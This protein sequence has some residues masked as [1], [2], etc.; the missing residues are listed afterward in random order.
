[1]KEKLMGTT[2]GNIHIYKEKP[3]IIKTLLSDEHIVLSISKDWVSILNPS[4]GSEGSD[5]TAK[6]ISKS[7]S[8]PVFAFQYH[9]DDIMSLSMYKDGKTIARHYMNCSYV[10]YTKN[11]KGFVEGIGLEAK[12]QTKLNKIFRCNNIADKVEM[13]EEFLALL[14]I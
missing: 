6:K 11:A 13:L 14:F 4:F 1:M 8:A 12:S 7:L 10:P 5:K 2:L 9:D 3:E